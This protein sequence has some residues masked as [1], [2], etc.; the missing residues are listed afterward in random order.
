MK[1]A[2]FEIKRNA[3]GRYYFV[4][5]NEEEEELLVS[6]SFSDRPQLEKYLANMRESVQMADIVVGGEVNP[7]MFK[8]NIDCEGCTFSLLDF[9]KEIIYQSDYFAELN[10]C[11]LVIIQL[12][13]LSFSAGVADLVRKEQVQA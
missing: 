4:F 13:K 8:I 6:G 2:V 7:P 11:M 3:V 5:K 1:Q 10:D 9:N 12:K